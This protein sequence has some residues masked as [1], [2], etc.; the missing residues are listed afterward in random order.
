MYAATPES[1]RFSCGEE[2]GDGGTGG[3]EGLATQIGLDAAEALPRED[4]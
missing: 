3:I 2:P 4:V 1:A